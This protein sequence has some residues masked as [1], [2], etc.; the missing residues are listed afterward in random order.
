MK[1]I[2]CNKREFNRFMEY[3]GI[4][5][6]NVE[7]KDMMFISVNQSTMDMG[8]VRDS[9]MLKSYFKRQHPNVHIMHFGDYGEEYVYKFIHEGPT[10]F[11]NEYKA[12]KLYEFIKA[13]KDKSIAIVHCSAG[14]SRSGAI[15]TFIHD[16]YGTVTW[17]EFKRTNPR[18]QP[19]H[20]VLKLLRAEQEKD[21]RS[22]N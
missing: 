10:G 1:V 19:N 11:F 5:D 8:F 16:L 20:H 17:E 14:I 21:E 13:N 18:I 2:I 4:D 22:R 9:Y 15:G 12:K 6:S 3:N 7:S